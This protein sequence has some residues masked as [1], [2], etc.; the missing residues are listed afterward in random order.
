MPST[1]TF[2]VSAVAVALAAA[3]GCNRSSDNPDDEATTPP[4]G[5]TSAQGT[6]LPGGGIETF[7]LADRSAPG[8]T[9][10]TRLDSAATGVDLVNMLDIDYPR[11]FLYNSGFACGGISIGDINGDGKPDLFF[12][13]GRAGNVLYLQR[14]SMRFED[15]T[16][17]AGVAGGPDDWAS[18]STLVDIDNDGD[19]DIYV[20]NYDAPNQLFINPGQEGAA[21]E[22]AAESWGL[23]IV[24]ASLTPAF[25]DYD[26]DG[27][28]DVYILTNRYTDPDGRPT[29]P[30]IRMV[31]GRP[32]V[33]AEYE[34][35]Y[36]LRQIGAQNWTIEEGGRADHLLRNDDGRF[37]DVTAEAGM[38]GVRGHG[39]SSTWFD[40]DGD[41]W[42]DLHVGNDYTDAD[43]LYRN[44]GDGTFTD[45]VADA[46][47]FTSWS[48]MGADAGDL[49]GDGR[50]DF[51]TADMANTTHYK[52]KV[53]MGEMGDRQ[54]FLE[55][56]WP[57]QIMRNVVY[58]NT[59]T[60]RFAE[61]GFLSGLAKSD[62][63]WAVKIADFDND[64]L[65]DV[66]LTNGM[67]RNFS[68]ADRVITDEM[69]V[70]QTEW[71][72]WEDTPPL[73][74]ANLAFHNLGDMHFEKVAQAWG[75]GHV[76]MSYSAATADLDGDGDLDLVVNNLDEPSHIYQNNSA[77]GHRVVI[78][79]IGSQSN[80]YGVGAVV[81]VTTSGGRQVRQMMPATGFLSTNDTKLHFG[82]GEA[83]TIETLSVHWPSGQVQ[84]FDSIAADQRL[85]IT[86]PTQA[87]DASRPTPTEPP[88][89]PL[90]ASRD[91]IEIGLLYAHRETDYDDFAVQPLLPGRL[92]QLG[93]GV[94]VGDIDGDGHDDIYLCGPAG[95]AGSLRVW[96]DGRYEQ[97]SG[98]WQRHFAGEEMAALMLDVD[99]DGDRDLLVT[100][101][102]YELPRGAESQRDRLYLNDGAGAF[103]YA[104]DALPILGEVSGPA[105]A[106]DFDGDGDLD[107]FIGARTVPGEY[108]TTPVSRLLRNDGGTFSDVTASLAP[109]LATVGMVTGAAWAD[110]DDDGRPDLLLSLDW[111]P[112]KRFANTEAGLVDRTQDAGLAGRLGWFN[113]VTPCDTDGDG[114]I[115]LVAMNYGLNTKYG[116]PSPDYL[117]HIFYG[118]FNGDGTRNL[119]E[120]K[121]GQDHDLLPVRG[122]S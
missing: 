81:H 83:D 3:V 8:D 30:P 107:L 23:A 48:T 96:R 92:S 78:E 105:A 13:R 43:R 86:E 119:V 85:V 66:Y 69:R 28:M 7:A 36:Y 26:H 74:E 115:D 4:T 47:P 6:T 98:P 34:Q 38:G 22:E 114:D 97:V 100:A 41:G 59:G 87:D 55:T 122:F 104:E 117:S 42:I 63:T 24:D 90:L 11:D 94:A 67:A 52:S 108:P 25:A 79:L 70:G 82:L 60:G 91:L 102:S 46:M 75:L 110:T 21:F 80:R 121:P 50:L 53:S 101:G 93:G 116:H 54:F 51:M 12:S 29:D 73:T 89:R 2:V 40:F 27:D 103:T 5:Q 20:C 17:Q 109:E 16:D 111:G 33:L 106:A 120:A 61:A 14:D 57:R 64:G 99:G 62:W 84:R 72:M 45:V 58:M 15:V 118:D 18:G 31:N 65:N 88:A 76:G 19:L 39:L 112:I 44:N 35:F 71:E 1:H 9:L 68:N 37:V 113:S 32:E 56:A 77:Q 95:R 49:D 10:F